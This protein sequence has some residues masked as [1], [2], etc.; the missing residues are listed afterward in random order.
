METR[1]AIDYDKQWLNCV[2]AIGPGILIWAILWSNFYCRPQF[3]ESLIYPERKK[4]MYF[5]VLVTYFRCCDRKYENRIFGHPENF[6]KNT[7][8]N[9]LWSLVFSRACNY[10]LPYMTVVFTIQKSFASSPK[11]CIIFLLLFFS[12]YKWGYWFEIR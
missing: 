1:L 12:T 2:S 6:I 7:I 4:P 9:D 11:T 5:F 8:S 3:V 10:I